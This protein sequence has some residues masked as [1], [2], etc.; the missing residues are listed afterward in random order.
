MTLGEFPKWQMLRHLDKFKY[1][2]FNYNFYVNGLVE[3]LSDEYGWLCVQRNNSE[4]V[5]PKFLQF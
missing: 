4:I 3:P 5:G 1:L 2:F